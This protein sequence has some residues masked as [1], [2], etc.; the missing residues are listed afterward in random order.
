M[1][2][3][4]NGNQNEKVWVC[5][6]HFESTWCV[7]MCMCEFLLDVNARNRLCVCDSCNLLCHFKQVQWRGKKSFPTGKLFTKAYLYKT[8]K[9]TCPMFCGLCEAYDTMSNAHFS[10]LA[11]I[12]KYMY[13]WVSVNPHV[14]RYTLWLCVYVRWIDLSLDDGIFSDIQTTTNFTI[15]RQK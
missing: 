7:C 12:N 5:S 1:G 3:C 11:T 14:N 6:I 2:H 8:L 10:S 4:R 9:H 15:L 13:V